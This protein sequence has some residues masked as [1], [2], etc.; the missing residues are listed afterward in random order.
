MSQNHVGQ[1]LSFSD[2]LCTVRYIGDVEGTKGDWL[3][4]EWDDPTRGKHSGQH[5]RKKYFTCLRD[6]PTA[7]SFVRPSRVPDAPRTFVEALKHKYAS[8]V[9]QDSGLLHV[10]KNAPLPQLPKAIRISGKEVEEVGF[11]KI[12]R[13]LA[14][15]HELVIV[16][17]DGLRMCNGETVRERAPAGTI[18]ETSPKIGELDLSR[19]LFE[20]WREVV[21]ICEE[22]PRLR[23]LRINGNRLRDIQ[24]SNDELTRYTEALSG[25]TTFTC[26]DI[27][28]SW[29][30]VVQLSTT[31]AKLTS[32][33]ASNNILKH[34]DFT[35]LSLPN[36]ITE[37]ILEDNE[38]Q[39]L[40]DLAPVTSLPV[41]RRLVLKFNLISSVHSP[42]TP[43]QPLAF[44]ATLTDLDLSYN[45]IASWD[46]INALPKVFPGLTSLRVSH[47]P[48]YASLVAPDGKPLSTDTGYLLTTARLANLKSINFGNISAKERLNAESYYLSLIT[49]ELSSALPGKRQDIIDAHPRYAELCEEYGAPEVASSAPKVNPNSLAARLL[50][51]R[52]RLADDVLAKLETEGGEAEPLG[53][54]VGPES[55][56]AR[57]ERI[58]KDREFI[59]K[60]PKSYTIYSTLGLIGKELCLPPLSLR[61]FWETGEWDVVS[62][63]QGLEEE[64]WDSEAEDEDG[65]DQERVQR[66]VELV[67]GT[68]LVGTWVEGDEVRMLVRLKA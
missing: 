18:K 65:D 1:R 47:N 38:F 5:G 50:T 55:K 56:A 36:S 51:I 53:L 39:S 14:H 34:L 28:L 60:V 8:D 2:A 68:R 58:L 17:L 7:A 26:N 16:I 22:L 25:I 66:V 43:S 62:K 35:D 64:D 37:L 40:A 15:L 6:S 49:S 4:V 9:L 30:E 27:M 29:S 44:S 59:S 33:S 67:A 48:L 45:Q 42:S 20:E 13:R 19:N 31:F 52:F 46:L 3:G 41:L 54:Y 12:A 63:D 24:L 57:L 32:L 11:E 10:P 61:L 21:Q 23:G